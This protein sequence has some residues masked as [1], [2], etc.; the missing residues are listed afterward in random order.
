M[1]NFP[2]F[3]YLLS[4]PPGSSAEELVLITARM[5]VHRTPETCLVF[6]SAPRIL[7]SNPP[8]MSCLEEGEGDIANT[9][10]IESS[11]PE[12]ECYEVWSHEGLI[13][14]K[15]LTQDELTLCGSRLLY[16]SC[17][18][19]FFCGFLCCFAA[20][21]THPRVDASWQRTHI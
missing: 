18:L 4:F 15:Q 21:C 2:I 17:F 1:S 5:A 11:K 7:P 10:A 9:Y 14:T 3:S 13:L 8:P 6:S 16:F 19:L 20:V 12:E